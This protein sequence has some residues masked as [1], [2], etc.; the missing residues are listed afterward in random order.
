MMRVQLFGQ[1]QVEVE[2]RGV[3]STEMGGVKPRQIL[4]I[5][6][7]DVGSP[8]AKDH[9]AEQLWSG[10]PPASYVGTLESYV[11]VLRR[12]LGL[13]GSR[14]SILATSSS[15]Y[16][17]DPEHVVV[18]LGEYRRLSALARE[19]DAATALTYAQ[20]ALALVS[21]DLLASEP[22]VD[23]AVRAR[24]SFRR[25]HVAVCVRAAGLATVTG[26]HDT[27]V[28]LAT[29]AAEQDP[30][31]EDAGQQLMRALWFAGRRAQA[32]RAY[33]E[34]RESL[35]D[36]LGDEPGQESHELYL[37]ILRDT[38]STSQRPDSE[39]GELRVLLRLLR[40]AIDATPGIQAPTSDARLSEIAVRAIARD[41]RRTAG[42]LLALA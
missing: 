26:D 32:L 33:A 31:S 10:A 19:A 13:S 16:V 4:E 2:G 6:A 22:Y 21:G 11:C 36:Q 24:D 39:G 5:L 28:R 37:T 41:D 9:L 30:L 12:S 3:S 20:Q 42:S 27:A 25:G 15:G 7:R 17:L 29:H 8:V 18:D 38:E 14:R 34:L 1:T 23:W 40:Q 35:C